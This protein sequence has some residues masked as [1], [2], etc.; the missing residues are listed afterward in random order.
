M[1]EISSQRSVVQKS[2]GSTM[3]GD[4]R[5][6]ERFLC[7]LFA[8]V[9]KPVSDLRLLIFGLCAMLF[10]LCFPDWAQQPA[11]L[12]RIGYVELGANPNDPGPKVEGFRQGLR[13]LGYI[14]GK[15]ILTEYRFLD[16]NRDRI[17]SV[18]AEFV[19]LKVD[20]IVVDAPPVVRALKQATK[21]IP[22][23]IVT[24]QDPVAAGYVTS[25]AR[26]GG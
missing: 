18:V 11:K 25:L 3:S 13:G 4:A 8:T 17:P 23:V 1:T 5:R 12:P 9:V 26:P 21:T 22:I 24:T 2:E 19:Q 20:V 6:T 10:P 15:N 7:G 14:E 16:G